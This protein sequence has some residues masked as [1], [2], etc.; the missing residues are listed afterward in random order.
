MLTDG[1]LMGTFKYCLKD[2]TFSTKSWVIDIYFISEKYNS[3]KKQ[4][5]SISDKQKMLF[6][7]FDFKHFFFEEISWEAHFWVGIL[8][9]NKLK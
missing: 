1:N 2:V 7:L 4:H 6:F 8:V 3:L 9:I 5:S